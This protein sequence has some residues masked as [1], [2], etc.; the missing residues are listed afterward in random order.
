MTLLSDYFWRHVLGRST[1]R[2]RLALSTLLL[3]RLKIIE[4]VLVEDSYDCFYFLIQVG[5]GRFQ[6][7]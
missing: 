1:D 2:K 7:A 6:L 3:H 5:W 4:I